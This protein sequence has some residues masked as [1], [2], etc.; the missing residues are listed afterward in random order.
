MIGQRKI[1]FPEHGVHVDRSVFIQVAVADLFQIVRVDH[2]VQVLVAFIGEI[3]LIVTVVIVDERS[4]QITEEKGKEKRKQSNDEDGAQS[5]GTDRICFHK[6][7]LLG[8]VRESNV[9]TLTADALENRHKVRP[10]S[11]SQK[12]ALNA[13]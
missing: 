12:Q 10:V 6:K 13:F 7:D 4:D 8:E 11:S 1:R 9:F 3:D 2:G 5:F